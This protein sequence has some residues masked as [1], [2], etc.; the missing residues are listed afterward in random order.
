MYYKLDRQ[1]VRFRFK[2]YLHID[3]VEVLNTIKSNL[4]NYEEIKNIICPIFNAFPLHTSKR[5]DFENF[6]QAVFIKDNKQL[7]DAGMS[8]IVSL[9][10]T[11]NTKREIFTYNT[12]K[13][14]IIINPN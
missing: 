14:Q 5:L 6:S 8:K 3:D 1:Y 2:I 9:K 12:T 13:P 11:M 10:N 4:N 7:S